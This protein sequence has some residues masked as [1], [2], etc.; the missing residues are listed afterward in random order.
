MYCITNTIQIYC[1]LKGE[2][3]MSDFGSEV[4]NSGLSLMGKLM[5]AL[6][7]VLEKIFDTIK[8]RT[9]AE[10]KL[11]Q[12]ELKEAK[13]RIDHQKLVEKVEG[14]AGFV[15]HKLLQKAGVPLV[16][17]GITLDDAGMKELAARCKREGIIITGVEDIRER[18]L[19]GKKFFCIECR[20]SDLERLGQLAD[21]MNDEKRIGKIQEEIAKVEVENQTLMGRISDIKA[22]GDLSQEDLDKI[23]AL[24]ASVEENGLVIKGLNEQ[25]NEIRYGHSQELNQEQAQGVVEKAV[26]GET[27][28]GVTFDEA[29]DRWTGGTIDKDTTSYVVDAKDPERYIVCTAKN[30][31]FRDQEYTKTTYEVYNGSKQVYATHD[32]RFEGRPKDYWKT[33]KA[34]MREKGGFGDLVLKFYLAKE[35]EAYRQNYMKQNV[36]ELDGLQVGEQERDYASIFKM[37]E[38]KI[39][40]CGGVYQE[41]AVMLDGEGRPMAQ[42]A[43]FVADKETGKPMILTNDMSEAAQARVAEAVVCGKQI[44]NYKQLAQ[45]EADISAA[46]AEVL[47]AAEGTPEQ[48]KAQAELDRLTEKYNAALEREAELIKDRKGINAIQAEQEVRTS[49]AREADRE[50]PSVEKSDDRRD[51]R[52]AENKGEG[53]MPMEQYE[54]AIAE[55]KAAAAKSN[56]LGAKEVTKQKT[57]PKGGHER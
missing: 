4:G 16:S 3:G 41:G 18:D 43:G 35:L 2:V 5:E 49:P 23:A 34:A 44:D 19:N 22:K 10:Y 14:K 47:I 20:Q 15:N 50:A 13:E 56:S 52:V 31:T 11:K 7:K 39:D 45:L 9:S 17:A 25:I 40:E 21:L 55:K 38:A 54:A 48:Q 51:D 29:L 46:R 6:L 8:E 32:G 1:E 42:A 27:Q 30:D 53:R 28:R 36:T 33:E 26:N 57:I 12:A 24:E 37:L